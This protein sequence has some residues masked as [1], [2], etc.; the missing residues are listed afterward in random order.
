MIPKHVLQERKDN[1]RSH[2]RP[3]TQEEEADDLEPMERLYQEDLK[4]MQSPA[5]APKQPP[6]KPPSQQAIETAAKI[7]ANKAMRQTASPKAKET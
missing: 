7:L 1:A 3:N 6:L 2:A 4:K 5:E